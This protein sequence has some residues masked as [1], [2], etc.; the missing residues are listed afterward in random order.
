MS[1]Q[2]VVYEPGAVPQKKGF[3]PLS[4]PEISGNAW[5]Y[6]KECLDTN[7]VSSAGPFVDRFEREVA[8]YVGARHAIA[9]ASGTAALHAGLLG[10]GVAPGDEVL[11]PTLTF[12]AT[13]NAI[14][15]CGAWPVFMDSD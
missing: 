15:Y 13:A 3:I 12:V 7:W 9:V 1:Q 6:V 11:V 8:A 10:A 2:A 4:V 5:K 14:R